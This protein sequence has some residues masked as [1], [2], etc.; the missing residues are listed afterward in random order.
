MKVSIIVP[1]YNGGSTL[2][3]C[4]TSLSAQTYTDIEII[5]VNDG[6]T[7]NTATLA[8]SLAHGDDRIQV[9]TQENGGVSA[10][11]NTGIK[12]A[13]GGILMFVDGDDYVDP[14]YCRL[15]VENMTTYESDICI[16]GYLREEGASIEKHL[17]AHPVGLMAKDEVMVKTS[18]LDMGNFVGCKA[19][20][21]Y[22]FEHVQFLEGKNYEDIR[23]FYQLVELAAKISYC[24]VTTYHYVQHPNS[25]VTTL[26]KRNIRDSL[27]AATVQYEYFARNYPQAAQAAHEYLL[28]VAVRY[29]LYMEHDDLYNQAQRYLREL[30][31]PAGLKKKKKYRWPMILFKRLPFTWGLVRWAAQRLQPAK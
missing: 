19:F 5:I 17:L 6:S 27:E 24:P 31:I 11:R 23:I 25:I 21:A 28:V 8:T 10:A 2:K 20:R 13:T 12:A 14:D 3:K 29:C 4:V 1:T 22:L 15:A 9:I 7:D 30:P 26:S 18:D 16:M